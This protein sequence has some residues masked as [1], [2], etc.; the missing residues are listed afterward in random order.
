[1]LVLTDD[2]GKGLGPFAMAM[3]IV[4]FG[5]RT[6]ALALAVCVGWTL[7]GIMLCCPYFTIEADEE[8]TKRR[9]LAGEGPPTCCLE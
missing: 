1:M 2:L 4:I 5:T 7:A 3:L 9:V 6:H 8:E